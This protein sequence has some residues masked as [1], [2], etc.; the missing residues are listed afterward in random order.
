MIWGF[1]CCSFIGQMRKIIGNLFFKLLQKL[2]WSMQKFFC[3]LATK[4]NKFPGEFY[5]TQLHVLRAAEYCFC[6][7]CKTRPTAVRVTCHA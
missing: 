1:P 5:E 6:N 2:L 4:K 3:R 7:F